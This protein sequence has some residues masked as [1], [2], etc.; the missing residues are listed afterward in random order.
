MQPIYTQF[1]LQLQKLSDRVRDRDLEI[2][3]SESLAFDISKKPWSAR[4]QIYVSDVGYIH[5]Y[6][7]NLREWGIR[8]HS[9]GGLDDPVKGHWNL[10]QKD[11]CVKDKQQREGLRLSS[12]FW[13]TWQV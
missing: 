5:I 9:V 7:R 11:E 13:L 2:V 4:S 1:N 8:K 10:M 3:A 6:Q 12:E